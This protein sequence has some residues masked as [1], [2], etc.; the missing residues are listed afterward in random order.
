M[1]K[2]NI[3]EDSFE[4]GLFGFKVECGDDFN[5]AQTAY[6]ECINVTNGLLDLERPGW[7]AIG[8]KNQ[9]D[10]VEIMRRYATMRQCSDHY[11]IYHEES[12]QVADFT[13]RQF[14]PEADYPLI[15]SKEEWLTKLAQAWETEEISHFETD[16]LG[17]MEEGATVAHFDKE[18]NYRMKVLVT[19]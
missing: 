13:F 16:E 2:V 6:S 10:T 5:T 8:A 19:V 11:T 12:D 14:D 4:E 15:C 9:A 17:W 1:S 18:D 3:P 7:I